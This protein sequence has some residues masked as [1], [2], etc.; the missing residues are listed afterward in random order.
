MRTLSTLKP[1]HIINPIHRSDAT[2]EELGEMTKTNNPDEID[3]D[4]FSSDDD[5]QPDGKYGF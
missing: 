5:A 3:I 4:D 2:E 1:C